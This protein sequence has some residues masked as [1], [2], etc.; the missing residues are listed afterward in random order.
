[1]AH[2]AARDETFLTFARRHEVDA[3]K[4]MFDAEAA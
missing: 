2:R 3:L 4:T 1:M